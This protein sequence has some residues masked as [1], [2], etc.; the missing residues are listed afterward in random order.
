MLQKYQIIRVR[1]HSSYG[2][3]AKASKHMFR[4]E[5]TPNAD[6]SMTKQNVLMGAVGTEA[7]LSTVKGLVDGCDA[8]SKTKPV[9]AIEYMITASPEAFKREGGDLSDKSDYFKKSMEWLQKKHGAENIVAASLHLDEK[10]PHLSVFVVPVVNQKAKM[11]KRSV[12]QAGG[13]RKTIEI[14]KPAQ[15]SLNAKHFLGGRELLSKMQDSFHFDVGSRFK[16]DRGNIGSRLKHEKMR[17]YYKN[18]ENANK[19][20]A[21]VKPVEL[22]LKDKLMA[23]VGVKTKTFKAFEAV[24]AAVKV[25]ALDLKQRHLP[26]LMATANSKILEAELKVEKIKKKEKELIEKE[27]TLNTKENSIS[28][29]KSKLEKAKLL[30]PELEAYRAKDPKYDKPT[31]VK[32]PTPAP[33]GKR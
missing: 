26:E 4:E 23:V 6:A 2:S 15:K 18:L 14:E 5:P 10:T 21:K 11:I 19:D 28:E 16:L 20:L 33:P 9:L 25:K 17:D 8:I 12:N 30:E 7:V 24:G 32:P 27:R 1:K 13:G 22:G 3:I 31:T 29:L